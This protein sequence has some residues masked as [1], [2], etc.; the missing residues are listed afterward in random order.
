MAKKSIFVIHKQTAPH[1]RYNLCLQLG[2]KLISWVIPKGPPL[3]AA[4]KQRALQA[5]HHPLSYATRTGETSEGNYDVE[6]WDIGTFINIKEREGGILPLAQCLKKGIIEVWFEG[7]KIK[8]AYTLIK[9]RLKKN[10]NRPHWL[11]FN[12]RN[13]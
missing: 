9:K 1:L 5:P 8:G 10:D 12:M 6:I 7:A 4:E 2:K 13:S 3:K 11:F